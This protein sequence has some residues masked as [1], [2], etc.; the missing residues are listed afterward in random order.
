MPVALWSPSTAHEL[1][2]VIGS[3]SLG[4]WCSKSTNMWLNCFSS[5]IQADTVDA[6]VASF[7]GQSSSIWPGESQAARLARSDSVRQFPVKR[8]AM[9][10]DQT[11]ESAGCQGVGRYPSARNSGGNSPDLRVRKKLIPAL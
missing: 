6:T 9:M 4:Q 11:S 8:I 2:A 3:I 10:R 5:G 1:D 7:T